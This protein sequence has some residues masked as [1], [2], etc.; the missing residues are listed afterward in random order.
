VNEVILNSHTRNGLLSPAESKPSVPYP[1]VTRLV[2]A[3]MPS[4]GKRVVTMFRVGLEALQP[5]EDLKKLVYPFVFPNVLN[6]GTLITVF[7]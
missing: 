7:I 2:S 6:S 5:R 4:V 3:N 1:D